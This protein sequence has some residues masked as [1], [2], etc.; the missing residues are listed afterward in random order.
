[1]VANLFNNNIDDLINIESEGEWY[2]VST[3]S[4]L[5]KL[6]TGLDVESE[7]EWHNVSIKSMLSKLH[8]SPII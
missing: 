6:H 4:I 8:T 3:K 1:M 2:D 5:S 7:G